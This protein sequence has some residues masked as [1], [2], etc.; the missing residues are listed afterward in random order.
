M[1]NLEV[2][3]WLSDQARKN[4]QYVVEKCLREQ[5]PVGNVEKDKLQKNVLSVEKNSQVKNQKTNKLAPK[6]V[7]IH[8]EGKKIQLHNLEKLKSDAKIVE[9]NDGYL[10]HI[11][12][13][14]FARLIV[15]MNTIVEKIIQCGKEELVQNEQW[16][17]HQ[18]NGKLVVKLSG[19][20]MTPLV[21]FAE[22]DS[23]MIN[24]LTKFITSDPS[25]MRTQDMMLTTLY[26]YVI[27]VI[28]GSIP[29]KI[30]T[31]YLEKINLQIST[32][33][34]EVELDGKPISDTQRYK[35]CGNAVTTNV[36][37]H[38]FDNWDLKE[39]DDD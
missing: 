9:K 2:D 35:C 18:E 7:H 14:N 36:I 21:N 29:A 32:G 19:N 13:E 8:Y 1:I 26:Y 38:I 23:V 6:S 12:Q 37:T 15:G 33:W 28:I 39:E 27:G 11:E 22:K 20:E 5:K 24:K 31:D 30:N 4:V 3:I 10:L 16:Q 34:T 17:I 25:S